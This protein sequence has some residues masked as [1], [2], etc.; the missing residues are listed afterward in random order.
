MFS[1]FNLGNSL[2]LE[3]P[4][5]MVIRDMAVL[6]S[7]YWYSLGIYVLQGLALLWT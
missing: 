2:K 5:G 1:N 7:Y 4:S 3:Q 6:W